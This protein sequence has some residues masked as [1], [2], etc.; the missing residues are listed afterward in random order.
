LAKYGVNLNLK[1]LPK[2][3]TLGTGHVRFFYDKG[4]YTYNRYIEIYKECKLR[5]FNVEFYGDAWHVYKDYPSLYKD[6]APTDKDFEAI[7]KRLVTKDK[8]YIGLL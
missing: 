1:N 2:E 7:K 3:F 8:R 4:L 6:Y 5:N